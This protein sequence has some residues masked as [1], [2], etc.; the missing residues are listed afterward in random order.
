MGSTSRIV[1]IVLAVVFLLFAGAVYFGYRVSGKVAEKFQEVATPCPRADLLERCKGDLSPCVEGALRLLADE[2][3]DCRI[4]AASWLAEKTALPDEEDAEAAD[5]PEDQDAPAELEPGP[6]PEP[7]VK[8]GPAVV[9]R[10]L[11]A[12]EAERWPA[13]MSD[14]PKFSC[15]HFE[16]EGSPRVGDNPNPRALIPIIIGRAPGD[17][18][19]PRARRVG[20]AMFRALEAGA[21]AQVRT[22]AVLLAASLGDRRAMPWQV[23]WN[24]DP[25]L[26]ECLGDRAD[27]ADFD[28]SAD[29][30]RWTDDRTWG[31][32]FQKAVDR[33]EEPDFSD[34]ER[35]TMLEKL[36]HLL[37]SDE[38]PQVRH[39]ARAA[40]NALE[41]RAN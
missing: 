23:L 38:D 40:I 18:L 37:V 39:Q 15:L 16:D 19:G 10:L 7:D 5:D 27:A 34:E 30:E 33:L 3:L 36:L 29:L 17:V 24:R 32:E 20:D 4:A 8:V 25:N 31:R 35:N 22:A 6:P 13:A 9:E 21:G 41:K 28:I 11:D 2:R 1:L 14:S 12:F 26:A